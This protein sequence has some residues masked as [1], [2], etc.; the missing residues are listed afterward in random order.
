MSDYTVTLSGADELIDRLQKA[1]GGAYLNGVLDAIGLE[2]TTKDLMK[3]PPV[4]VGSRYERTNKLRS[5]WTWA[6]SDDNEVLRIGSD[7]VAVPYNRFVMDR[8]EQTR[9]HQWHGWKTVQ[10]I[11]QLRRDWVVRTIREKIQQ[12]LDGKA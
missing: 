4:P 5:S 2:I 12:V 3:Y 10:G 7:S 11:I 9:V 6:V 8:D 1:G